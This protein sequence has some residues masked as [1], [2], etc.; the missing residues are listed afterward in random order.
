MAF[1]DNITIIGL[2]LII[3]YVIIQIFTFYGVGAEVYGYYICFYI[4]MMLFVVTL[5]TPTNFIDSISA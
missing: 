1:R 3:L 5:P 2:G 4:L